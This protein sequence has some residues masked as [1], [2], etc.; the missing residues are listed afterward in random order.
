MTENFSLV[1]CKI[2]GKGFKSRY[3][4]PAKICPECRK[5]EKILKDIQKGYDY[6]SKAQ[7]MISEVGNIFEKYNIPWTTCHPGQA[8]IA[9]DET[10]ANL[11]TFEKSVREEKHE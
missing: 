9:L 11:E 5:K 8:S 4:N 10:I 3:Y 7:S 1:K 2:C 6:I